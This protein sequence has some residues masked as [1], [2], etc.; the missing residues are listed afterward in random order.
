MV[1]GATHC[2]ELSREKQSAIDE[3]LHKILRINKGVPFKLIEKF[4]GKIRYV[5]KTVPTGENMMTPTN[6]ILQVIL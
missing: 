2:I 3:E 4:I 1:D 6:K 5:T